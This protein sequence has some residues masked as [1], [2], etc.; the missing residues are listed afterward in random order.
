[1]HAAQR[2]HRLHA[3]AVTVLA[4]HL[5]VVVFVGQHVPATLAWTTAV[6]GQVDLLQQ[7]HEVARFS[8]FTGRQHDRQ[9]ET[10][11]VAGVVYFGGQSASTAAETVCC[12][13]CGPLFSSSTGR[14]GSPD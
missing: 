12:G 1:M 2:Y 7:R 10:V 6:A 4:Q 8:F 9:R 13:F 11:T 3:V 5:A 14:S